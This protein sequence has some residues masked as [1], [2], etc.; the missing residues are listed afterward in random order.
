MAKPWQPTDQG[1]P[2]VIVA[3]A[4]QINTVVDW[5]EGR[6]PRSPVYFVRDQ[7][8]GE[9]RPP[10]RHEIACLLWRQWWWRRN[11]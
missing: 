1:W 8:T 3:V 11:S 4:H 5:D 10:T 6:H 9:L 2:T 7:E